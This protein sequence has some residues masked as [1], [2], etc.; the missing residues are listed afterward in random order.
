MLPLDELFDV[1]VDSSE[2]GMRKP[3]PAIFA[4]TLD[5]LGVAPERTAFLDDFAGNVTAARGVGM[6]AILVEPD[7]TAAIGEVDALLLLD[8]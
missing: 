3:N 1:V 2:I 4:H 5:L 7:P 8:A 6:I